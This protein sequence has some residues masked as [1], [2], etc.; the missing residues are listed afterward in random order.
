MGGTTAGQSI[1]VELGGGGTTMI[2]LNDT[3][4]RTLAGVPSGAIIMPTNFWGTSSANAYIFTINPGYQYFIQ[5]I[6][7]D[8][9]GNV[10]VGGNIAYFSG[11]S[12]STFQYSVSPT[13]TLN[14]QRYYYYTSNNFNY[15]EGNNFPHSTLVDSSNT[16]Y[17]VGGN[18]SSGCA[19]LTSIDSSGNV[20]LNLYFNVSTGF[21]QGI[22]YDSSTNYIYYCAGIN[23]NGGRIF[24]APIPTSYTGGA[25]Y[26][27]T[28]INGSSTS[29]TYAT[30]GTY[31]VS[32]GGYN[33]N[34]VLLIGHQF[35]SNYN[36][37]A[38]TVNGSTV[39]Q[40]FQK[41]ITTSNVRFQNG[42]ISWGPTPSSSTNPFY[43][44]LTLNSSGYSAITQAV[45][46]GTTLPWTVS[47]AYSSATNGITPC[48][49]ATDSSG[50]VYLLVRLQQT[51]Q[52]FSHIVKFNSSGT[53][54]WQRFITFYGAGN[55][56][57]NAPMAAYGSDLLV[58]SS[59]YLYLAGNT[60]STLIARYEQFVL[61]IPTDGSIIGTFLASSSST[62]YNV[63]AMISYGDATASTTT[64]TWSDYGVASSTLSTTSTKSTS[65]TNPTKITSTQQIATGTPTAP[66]SS[67]GSVTF[68]VP[69]TYSWVCP[70]GV[71]SVSVVC[72]GAGGAGYTPLFNGTEYGGGGGGGGGL[73]Y[74][75]NY[76][77]TPG[78]SYTVVVGSPNNST[79][80]VANSG[81]GGDSYF[82]STSVVKGGGGGGGIGYANYSSVTPGGGYAGDGGGNGGSGGTA[83]TGV[84][85]SGGG[86]GAG[87][88]AGT[89]GAGGGG[90]GN[91]NAGGTSGSGGGGGGAG[92]GSQGAGGGGGVYVLGQGSNGNN[93][94]TNI[95]GVGGSGGS[96]AFNPTSPGGSFGGGGG[97]GWYNPSSCCCGTIIPGSNVSGAP[98]YT[99]AVRIMW[100]GSSRAFP[101]TNVGL[102]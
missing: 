68:Y 34:S 60:Y 66:T 92:C 33:S 41:A 21:A 5:G 91:T 26:V 36:I 51:P 40:L 16:W 23:V 86:G 87:G 2:S 38:F 13:G 9:S 47:F 18:Q 58:D 73:G 100:P 1:E 72:I 56:I 64:L 93:G 42:K 17:W 62:T 65:F 63:Y 94:G 7:F 101:S 83:N 24:I 96:A 77:V 59:G 97:A 10:I 46:F 74:K 27:A 75:N 35:N 14:F 15:P 39:T 45:P 67:N 28:I 12:Y 71:T 82:V 43:F 90:V 69:G 76:S 6:D 8:S 37:T 70:T 29:A 81:A 44:M 80:G 31:F 55:G 11:S 52:G 4:V 79:S 53:I 19:A 30:N 85:Y 98:G 32:V 57:A 78:N 22:A 54:Q 48:A 89:G 95:G 3:N 102:P 99:G 49:T 84:G 25:S 88:Y 61:K 50:N 20:Q